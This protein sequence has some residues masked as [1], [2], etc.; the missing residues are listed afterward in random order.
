MGQNGH[1]KQF[2]RSVID[3][4]RKVSLSLFYKFPSC[5]WCCAQLQKFDVS[6]TLDLRLWRALQDDL[7]IQSGFYMTSRRPSCGSRI[8]SFVNASFCNNAYAYI[9]AG[10]LSENALLRHGSAEDLWRHRSGRHLEHHDVN[11]QLKSNGFLN[12][13][14]KVLVCTSKRVI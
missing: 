4:D 3:W 2:R 8:F 10:H 13:H 14:G 9:D 6:L 12:P 7:N 1:C 5:L 11:R